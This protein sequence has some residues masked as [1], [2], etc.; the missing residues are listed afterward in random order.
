LEIFKVFPVIFGGKYMLLCFNSPCARENP[1]NAMGKR[2]SF[3]LIWPLAAPQKKPRELRT[4][5]PGKK[6]RGAG[7]TPKKN[8]SKI[9]H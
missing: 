6:K 1:E 5:T 4:Q 8:P 3:L 9:I 2:A 7:S